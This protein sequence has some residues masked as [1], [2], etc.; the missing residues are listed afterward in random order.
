MS[1]YK[2][3]P[4]IIIKNGIIVD[5]LGTMPYQ[6]DVAIIGDKIDYIGNLQAI[7]APLVIDAHHKY[8]TPGFIDPHTH[9]DFTI[10]ANPECQ[11]AVRQGVTTEVVG[12]C[13]YSLDHVLQDIP[14]DPAGDSVTC[15][16]DIDNGKYPKGSM[17]AVLDKMEAM[18]AS[19]NTAWLCGHNALRR[20]AG[21]Y[22]T[23]YT[24]KQFRMMEDMLREAMES[25]FIGLSTGLEFVPGIVSRP[26]EVERLAMIAAEYDGNYSSH[27]RDEGTYLLEAV[28]EFLNVIR[29]SGL[30]GTVS[31]LNVKY[32]NGIPNDYLQKA[33]NMLKDARSIEK[34]NVMCD[35]LP[36]CFATGGALAM[37]PPWLYAN[38][39][40]EA[41]EIM[42]TPEGRAKIKADFRRY[43]RFL[44]AGQWERLLYVQ[45][46][47]MVEIGK[48]PFMELAKEWGKE[49]FDCFI[50]VMAAAE[51]IEDAQKVGMQ[52]MVFHEQTMVDSVVT[53]PIYMWQTDSRVTV[54]DGELSERC[55]NVQNYMSMAYFFVR[56]VRELG[57]ISIEK[58]VQKATSIPAKHYKL[59]KRGI[60]EE[61]YYADINV[62]DLNELKIHSTFSDVCQYSSGMYYVIVNGTPV[63]AQGEHTGARS[64]RVL[65]HL[66]KK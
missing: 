6:A 33:M 7:E 15:I 37:L 25:G 21:L 40:D 58:A 24:E 56:Y 57:A 65:R 19:M 59:E 28:N 35:M 51:T 66:P 36:T 63:I 1:F 10:W 31:H 3:K 55:A 20:I 5:G 62:F 42:G 16:Y 34:L 29:K 52:G 22:T 41:R 17:A 13:G 38:G 48:K 4:D 9:S 30:R 47:Y 45:P 23:D 44:D 50:D 39:W 26:E 43:W 32:D 27:M 2:R 60:L 14:F 64:G 53:D 54:E 12:N 49:P 18:G 46:K 61:G 8:V 11:S